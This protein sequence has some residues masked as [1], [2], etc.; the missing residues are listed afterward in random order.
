MSEF[1]TQDF[2]ESSEQHQSSFFTNQRSFE[3]TF[4]SMFFAAQRTKIADIVAVV[5][6]FIQMQQSISF[7]T[8]ESQS[9]N[10]SSAEYFK[11]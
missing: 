7:S 5:V 8:T 6:R 3:T 4:D 2:A 10:S 11:K 9:I 1:L